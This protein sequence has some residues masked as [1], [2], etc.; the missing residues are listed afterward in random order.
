MVVSYRATG[1]LPFQVMIWANLTTVSTVSKTFPFQWV[2]KMP[3]HRSNREEERLQFPLYSS[4]FI[5][6]NEKDNTISD[7]KNMP[8]L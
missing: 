8:E 6:F 7:L 5:R 1:G 2:S 3:Q 4:F